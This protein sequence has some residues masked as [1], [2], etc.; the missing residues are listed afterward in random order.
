VTHFRYSAELFRA[1]ATW[2]KSNCTNPKLVR[3]VLRS[4][5]DAKAAGVNCWFLIGGGLIRSGAASLVHCFAGELFV[6][7]LT[8]A[9]AALRGV[10]RQ[11]VLTGR[12]RAPSMGTQAPVSAAISLDRLELLTPTITRTTPLVGRLHYEV[13]ANRSGPWCVRLDYQMREQYRHAFDYPQRPLWGKGMLDLSFLP[14]A[15]EP[16]V[17]TDFKGPLALFVRVFDMTPAREHDSWR[18]ISNTVATLA[19]VV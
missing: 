8:D 18:A 5:F 14:I 17:A 15:P 10:E 13:L 19:E 12:D 1:A 2:V 16:G 4:L 6:F 3:D 7:Q 9:Q 11:G